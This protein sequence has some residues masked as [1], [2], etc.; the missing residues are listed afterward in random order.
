MMT[1]REYI[2]SLRK[3]RPK[4][5]FMGR[6]IE[7]VA[8]DPITAPHVN[9]AAMT[10]ELAHDPR[11]EDVMTAVSHLTG[12]RINRFNHI[13]QSTEDLVKKVR[14]IRVLGQKTGSCFQRCVGCDAMN[15]IYITSYNIDRKYGTE[16]H[17]RVRQYIKYVQKNDLMPAGAMTD[18]KGD[19]SKRPSQ[20]ADKD[21]YVRIVEKREDGIVVR[22]AK[23]HI[24]G[25]VN[26]HEIIVMPTRALEADDKDYAVSF[27]VPVDAEGVKM[28][29]GRQ[30]NDLRRLDGDMDC[31][32]A[33]YATVGGEALV[34]FD[35]V[36]VPWERVFMCGEYDF[37][38]ELVEVFATF[39]RQN[40]GACKVGVAD[41][42]IGATAN[43]AEMQG[44]ARASHVVDKIT[45]MI[46]LAETC[47]CCT[48]ACSYEGFRTPSGAYMPNQL[49]ANVTKL[50]ITR[51]PYEWSR[52]AQDITGGIVIT[53]P[54]EKDYRNPETRDLIEKYLKGVAE[55][56]T[57]Q[58]MRMIRLVE[59]LSIGAEL[60]ES[61]HGAGSPQAQK[62]MIA[63][64]SNLEMKKEMAR[65]IA[66][67]K[68]DE[69]F[70]KIRGVTERE[71]FSK[72]K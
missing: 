9:A 12:E 5:Y 68:E 30:T 53:L 7:N 34:I 64:R 60:P 32:N 36:F 6:R 3:Y 51:F 62:I 67:I 43:V 18:V 20:Q 8:D 50:N 52:I 25:A 57:E 71:F 56:P 16:Y 54:S 14:M 48:L 66:G 15:A 1:G 40:Y 13:H 11:Y 24:T 70:R 39:H 49:L 72:L 28:I 23:A 2:E 22:G 26:S 46:H 41:V 37:A 55:T 19:R 33:K 65:I 47:W 38:G 61:M 29:F 42:L 31:G 21:L 69:H 27:A 63:R 45:E 44:I 58:R 35:D 17:E 10:Y 4:I 59:N